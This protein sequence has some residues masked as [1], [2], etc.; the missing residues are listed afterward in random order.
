M[1]AIAL[2]L[3]FALNC[4]IVSSQELEARYHKI[5]SNFIN[6]VKCQNRE[7]LAS[8]TAFPL[9][10]KYPLPDIKD[11]QDLLKRFD[12]VFDKQ[13]IKMINSSRPETDWY[14]V[15]W[16]GICLQSGAVWIDYDGRLRAI[17]YQSLAEKNKSARLIKTE[18]ISLHPSIRTFK[19]PKLILKTAKYKIRIDDMGSQNYR[20]ASWSLK[21]NMSDKPD[22]I[23]T[24]GHWIPEGSGGSYRY[25]FQK[26][27]YRYECTVMDLKEGSG[28]SY[29][30]VYKGDQKILNTTAHQ[31]IPL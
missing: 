31:Q 20:Y 26:G 24:N 23:I 7:K 4:M 6:G 8:M 30:T 5:V 17:T 11:K 25:D 2:T 19:E 3:I 13:L 18:K 27:D 21:N 9:K 29:L 14:S 22:L 12:E 15:G 10:R 1:K 28:A 16:R